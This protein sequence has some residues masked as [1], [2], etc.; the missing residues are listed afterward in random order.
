MSDEQKRLVF[1][2]YFNASNKRVV[3]I[4]SKLQL[5]RGFLLNPFLVHPIFSLFTNPKDKGL[6]CLPNRKSSTKQ[7]QQYEATPCKEDV[8]LASFN[9]SSYENLAHNIK[10]AA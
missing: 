7:V 10:T 1:Y 3:C 6:L 2:N 4:F 9:C 5:D 8:N